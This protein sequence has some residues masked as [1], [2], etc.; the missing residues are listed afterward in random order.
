MDLKDY[1]DKIKFQLTGGVIE[2]EINDKGLEK[3]VL[4]AME[5]MNRYYNV[6]DL[7]QVKASSCIDLMEYPEIESIL[8]VHRIAGVGNGNNS[9][10]DPAY[11]SQLQM[12]NTYSGYYSND[13]I[14]RYLNYATNQQIANTSST[15]LDFRYDELGKKLYVNYSV[16]TPSQLVIEFVP[17]LHDPSEVVTNFWQDI[18]YK[19]SLAHTKVILGRIRTRYVQS[20]ALWTDDGATL[21]AEGNDELSTLREQLR[22]ATDLVLPID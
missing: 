7:I 22:V 9:I 16:G 17:K 14:Y 19:L 21:L 20:N 1:V 8:S 3:I 12:Y 15:D 4:M 5:E 2:C 13:W 18:L 10:T 6:T 11:V